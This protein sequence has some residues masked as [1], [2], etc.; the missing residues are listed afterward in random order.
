MI[1]RRLQVWP[2]LAASL[3]AVLVP[4]TS[5]AAARALA[6][7]EVT[8]D[9]GRALSLQGTT[10]LPLLLGPCR[11]AGAA[12]AQTPAPKAVGP[13]DCLIPGVDDRCEAW[14]APRY[15]GP[16]A[17]ADYAGYGSF[18]RNTTV[19][20]HPTEDLLLVGGTSTHGSG[21]AL[22][23]DFVEIAYRASTG[24][25]V[26]VSQYEGPG[27]MTL[28]YQSSIALSPDGNTLYALGE[29]A[30]PGIYEYHTVVAAFDALTG[31]RRWARTYD[32]GINSI[33]TAATVINGSLTSRLYAAGTSR[34]SNGLPAG[35][36]TAIDPSDGEVVWTSKTGTASNGSRFNELA[37][38]PDGSTIYAGGG[39]HRGDGLAKNFLAVAF[40]STDGAKLWESRD[41]LTQ[42]DGFY[43]N[44]GVTD[45][46]VTPDGSRLVLSGIDPVSSGVIGTPSTS[47]ILTVAH[48]TT[49]GSLAWRQSYGGPV[50]GETHFY[51]NL[52]Q[53]MLAITPD[54]RTAVATAAINSASAT[55]TVAYDIA[56][57]A[58]RWGVESNDVQHRYVFNTYL[59]FYPTVLA[60]NDRAYVSNSRGFGVSQYQTVSMAYGLDDGVADWT[61]R[62]GTNRT[63]FTGSG[64]TPDGR[65]LFVTAADQ[66]LSA[67]SLAPSLDSVDLVTVAYDA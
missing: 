31:A 3:V 60:A 4:G 5:R 20:A 39:E 19:L 47:P 6:P 48:E 42:P 15:D 66:L 16:W 23:A 46:Q 59:G 61:G 55:G 38:S 64:L 13:A 24:V 65:R 62:L 67:V 12:E 57:G 45:L 10:G 52:F 22:D 51:F 18:E 43:G 2:I 9:A 63:L 56:T 26:W 27:A 1:A 17:G 41:T 11:E 40:R 58:Q 53:G 34:A 32:V 49:D 29:A 50:A 25:P 14:T 21:T 33:K 28:A 54:G 35:T 37:L 44:N 36:V 8:C 30:E 7:H